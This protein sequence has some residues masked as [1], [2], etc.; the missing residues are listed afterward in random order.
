MAVDFEI[1]KRYNIDD[2]VSVMALLRG[3]GGCPWDRVQTH[4]SIR[5]NLIEETY[6]VAEAIDSGDSAMLCEELGD[7]LM[8]VIFHAQM[9]AEAGRFDF[10]DVCDGLCQKLVLR[11]PHV[12]G[13]VTAETPAEVLKNWDE[14]KKKEK[15]QATATDTL[16]SVPKELPALMRA[17][18]LQHRAAKTGFDYTDTAGAM[19]DLDSET[20]ELKEAVAEGDKLH[21]EEELGD[22]LF[23][24][25][26]VS[27]F[28]KTDAEEALT[29][30]SEKFIRR[31][32]K[33][34]ALAAEEGLDMHTAGM[35]ELDT[36][37]KR[38][39]RVSD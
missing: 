25:V 26:N 15:G 28:V 17:E 7:L 34:E 20:A 22:L 5:K 18:K 19:A 14:I 13:D 38:A 27:R 36:L 2:L 37:W 9:E 1:K 32:A 6:E 21:I 39:K 33:V 24:A 12:F 23:A 4:Q 8:Q 11:H 29:R 3:E 31:F 35:D 30:S 16:L 10:D